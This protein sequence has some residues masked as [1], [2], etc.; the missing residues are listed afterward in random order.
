MCENHSYN[1]LLLTR[2]DVKQHFMNHKKNPAITKARRS[3][4]LNLS[5]AIGN[6]ICNTIRSLILNL[7]VIFLIS[8]FECFLYYFKINLQA[9]LVFPQRETGKE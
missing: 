1:S 5:A 4:V 8:H 3:G 6:E 7:D 2:T 9:N